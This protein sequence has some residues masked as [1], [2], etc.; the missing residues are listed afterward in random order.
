MAFHLL[1]DEDQRRL[2]RV[3]V[4]VRRKFAE[5]GAY[6]EDAVWTQLPRLARMRLTEMPVEDAVE[7]RAFAKLVEWLT[8]TFAS[9][10][11]D[12]RPSL[13]GAR[14]P[15]R[16]ENP[17]ADLARCLRPG[18]WEALGPDGRHALLESWQRDGAVQMLQNYRA[19]TPTA[20]GA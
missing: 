15:W 11:D 8:K 7:R 5:S 12:F 14:F 13:V 2:R 19:L 18:E 1:D 10:A 3:P 4:G 6:I 16:D 9:R 17:P 20:S